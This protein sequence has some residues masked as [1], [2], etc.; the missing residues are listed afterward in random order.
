MDYLHVPEQMG[1]S[2]SFYELPQPSSAFQPQIDQSVTAADSDRVINFGQNTRIPSSY[3]SFPG[4]WKETHF[5]DAA[6]TNFLPLAPLNNQQDN[7]L[8]E[9]LTALIG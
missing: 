9:K 4:M 8:G 7:I 1:L 3:H 6:L 5:N 2:T